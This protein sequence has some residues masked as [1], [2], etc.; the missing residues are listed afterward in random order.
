MES[1]KIRIGT[2]NVSGLNE[3]VKRKAI[4]RQL[5]EYDIILLQETHSI[6]ATCKKWHRDFQAKKGYWDHGKKNAR[7]TGILIREGLEVEEIW[8][9]EENHN[10]RIKAI[11]LKW[12]NQK[13]GIIS[14]YAPN[15]N[16][17]KTSEKDY[18]KFV[19]EL[20]NVIRKTRSKADQI[21]LGGDLN[22]VQ[23]KWDIQGEKVKLY[24]DCIEAIQRCM[25]S[26]R[27]VDIFREMNPEKVITTFTQFG[28]T[29][30]ENRRRLD[31]IYISDTIKNA[32][33]VVFN[34]T[35][36]HTDHNLLMIQIDSKTH[37]RTNKGLW[38]HNNLLNT[39]NNFIENLKEMI[40]KIDYE[41]LRGEQV[42]W[43]YTKYKIGL[44]SR[45]YSKKKAKEN[46]EEK[47]RL[48][49]E[50]EKAT[51]K[52]GVRKATVTEEEF[53]AIKGKVQLELEKEERET[54]F[55]ANVKY[56]EEGE[57]CT[58]YFFRQIKTNRKASNI[59]ILEK[60]DGT[61]LVG[62]EVGKE[63]YTFYEKL[64]RNYDSKRNDYE[65]AKRA[66]LEGNI[67]TKISAEQEKNLNKDLSKEELRK[68]LFGSTKEG[69]APGNDGLTSG[70]YRAI[71]PSICDLFHKATLEAM[72]KGKLSPSQTQ[73]VIRLI[74]KKGKDRKQ[75]KNWRPISL[76]NVDTKIIAK[77]LANRIK[78]T[79]Q[80]IIGKEQPGFM[81]NRGHILE[82]F[83]ITKLDFNDLS[84]MGNSNYCRIAF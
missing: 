17:E 43:E 16:W 52:E 31:Y 53:R 39:D 10:G 77:A 46:K 47:N 64:Y 41:E 81:K 55:R 7:G 79:L 67:E 70:L 45:E 3:Q 56:Y 9:E 23:S 34:T 38:R 83:L 15:I 50:L 27:L 12:K 71:W 78:T 66:F 40:T 82:S 24:K 59:N 37:R 57:K 33:E 28:K 76:I 58:A 11:V 44:F 21:I 25:E 20:E 49:T 74:E 75:I 63:I 61:K 29:R 54:I 65:K 51:E 68:A 5:R 1:G 30:A 8:E 80:D 6:E 73:S 13:L 42:K 35:I 14:V 48:I 26:N 72:E 84:L 62:N 60:D 36:T 18:I 19:E 32:T 69:K 4:A 22:L 2:L